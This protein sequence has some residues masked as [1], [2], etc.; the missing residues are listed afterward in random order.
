MAQAGFVHYEISNWCKPGH[1]CAHN[2]IYWR[3]EP[4][5][6]FGAG[7]HSSSIHR[8]WWDVRRP[9][10]YVE[11]IQS[12]D[13]AEMG[14]ED[15]D[16]PTSRGETMMLGLRLLQEG[17]NLARFTRRYGAPVEDFY[18]AEL[19]D[20]QERGLLEVTPE[21]IRLTPKGHFLSNQALM[22][23]IAEPAAE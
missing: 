1:E 16:E 5:Y 7:A 8:R 19:R 20:G 3:N 4:Y 9:A 11:R 21:C 23:F 18:S 12:G 15:I 6:G 17:V 22:L 13:S 2:L 10:D 14:H